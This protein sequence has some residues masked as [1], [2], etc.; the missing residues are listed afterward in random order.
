MLIKCN[1]CGHENQ[2]GS[3]FCREC[4]VKLDVEKMRPQV[5]KKSNFKIGDLI[6]NIVAIV[7]LL[8]VFGT[9]GL[10]FYPE[11]GQMSELSKK[12]QVKTDLKFQS[13]LKKINGDQNMPA[14]YV[15]TPEEVTYI[16]NNKL[17]EESE[18][19]T[20]YAVK[21]IYIS[22]DNYDNIVLIADSKF[23]DAIPVSFG[24]TGNF[25]GNK[26]KLAV[27]SA[28]MGHLPIP[29]FLQGKIISKFT[30]VT[31]MGNIPT[32]IS[33]TAK[34]EVENGDFHITVKEMVKK[35]KRR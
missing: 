14:K 16:Y 30:P 34:A 29:G 18:E 6:R 22:L 26:L 25:D 23:L 1:E 24:L 2:L 3:I 5:E 13:L 8:A 17:T 31:D 28:K 4:G 20:G 33:G 9:L 12:D 19:T 7:V 10:M 11:S 21:K 32:I 15:F 27:A 35:K